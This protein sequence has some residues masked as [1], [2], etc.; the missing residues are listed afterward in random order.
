MEMD[1]IWSLPIK[2][3]LSSIS[4]LIWISTAFW[5]ISLNTCPR[6][7]ENVDWRKH[8]NEE[9]YCYRPH[10]LVW[11]IKSRRLKWE[12]HVARM[13]EDSTFKMLTV[14]LKERDL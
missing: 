11:V 2:F 12:G 6:R 1:Q 7:D 3:H 10:N 8:H 9:C 4:S 5:C 13:E 14:N